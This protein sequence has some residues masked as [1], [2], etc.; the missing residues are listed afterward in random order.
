MDCNSIIHNLILRLI[1]LAGVN[2]TK[3]YLT[4]TSF[5]STYPFMYLL[6]FGIV[7]F[8]HQPA[9]PYWGQV[10]PR[11]H[12]HVPA[13]KMLLPRI[14]AWSGRTSLTEQLA[15][16]SG[17]SY[18]EVCVRVLH[19]AKMECNNWPIYLLYAFP[20][21]CFVLPGAAVTLGHIFKEPATINYPFEKGPLS[22]RWLAVVVFI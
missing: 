16:F 15:Q 13:T 14:P 4:R 6:Y 17:L 20:L 2:W 9:Y 18:S 22:P 12:R 10:S 1:S 5:I 8:P 3:Q 21:T 11:Q 19:C 7:S